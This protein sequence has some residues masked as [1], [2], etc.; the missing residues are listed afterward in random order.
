MGWLNQDALYCDL[1][2]INKILYYWKTKY[3]VGKNLV[4]LWKATTTTFNGCYYVCMFMWL[5]SK[6]TVIYTACGC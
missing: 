6:E 1:V 3:K 4:T 5:W 2:W